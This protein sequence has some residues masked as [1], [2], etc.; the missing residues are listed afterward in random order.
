MSQPPSFSDSTASDQATDPEIASQLKRYLRADLQ[1]DFRR[2]LLLKLQD[3]FAKS[4]D[5]GFKTSALWVGLG[6]LGLLT[7]AGSVYFNF[8]KA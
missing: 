4:P 3:P 1:P 2:H 8:L 6:A 5:G 7:L